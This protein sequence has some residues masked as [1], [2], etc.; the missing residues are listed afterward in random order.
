MDTTNKKPGFNGKQFVIWMSALV[1]GGVLGTLGL[2][3]LNNFFDFIATVY[4]R[5][6]QFVAVPTIALTILTTLASLGAKKGTGRIF[7]H[8]IVYTLLTTIAASVVGV[9]L[10]KIIAP[11]NLPVDLIQQ[12]QSSVPQNLGKLSYY[13]HILSVVPD[14]ILKPLSTGNVLSILLVSAAA[15]LT[16]AVMKASENIQVLLKGILGLQELLFALIRAL[17]WTLPLGIVAFAG[18]L[19]AQMSAG[20]IVGTLGKYVAVVLGGNVI[21]HYSSAVPALPRDQSAPRVPQHASGCADGALHQEFRRNPAGH[22]RIGGK[23]YEGET[24]SCAFHPADL[25]H[26]Q[27]ERVRGIHPRHLAVRHAERRS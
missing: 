19:S 13:D 20:V 1:L 7:L 18:Q 22:N 8:T 10:Y 24:G 14:N 5:L 23:Q 3:W 17:V 21:L 26:D 25:L 15:G 2:A 6:F 12:G 27:H 9:I 4:T 16:L 11:G